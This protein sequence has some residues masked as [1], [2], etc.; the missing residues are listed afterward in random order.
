M[1]TLMSKCTVAMRVPSKKNSFQIKEQKAQRYE[2]DESGGE[3]GRVEE[4]KKR[5]AVCLL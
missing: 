2:L 5:K 3:G 1:A 4:K